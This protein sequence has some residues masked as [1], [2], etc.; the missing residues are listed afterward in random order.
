[1]SMGA[2]LWAFFR[3]SSFEE[4]VSE[5]VSL[6]W[7]AD[8]VGAVAGQLAGAFYGYDAIPQPWL[9]TL[10]QYPLIL[11]IAEKMWMVR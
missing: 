11:E 5:A 7:D 1:M 10:Y 4:C 9:D 2:A 8:T 3:T 6:G